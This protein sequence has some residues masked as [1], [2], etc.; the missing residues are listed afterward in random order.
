MVSQEN[1]QVGENAPGV[2]TR[3]LL[4]LTLL[5]LIIRQSLDGGYN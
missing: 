1:E 5:N 3:W 4:Y 2:G